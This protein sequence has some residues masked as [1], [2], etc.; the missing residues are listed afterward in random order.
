MSWNTVIDALVKSERPMMALDLFLTMAR[1]GLM[2]SQATFVAVIHSCTS[3]RNSVC[4]ESVHAK[5]IRSG[6]ESDVIVGTALVDFYS[7]CD[8]FI[9]AHKCFDQIEEK[10]VNWNVREEISQGPGFQQTDNLGKYLGIQL[11]HKRVS[12]NFYSHII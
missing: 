2:P 5:I 12:M 9:S 3:L 10:N 1:R 8:K 6:F 7:K 11:H 4:G